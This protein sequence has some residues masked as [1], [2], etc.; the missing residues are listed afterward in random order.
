MWGEG[1]RGNYPLIAVVLC[2]IDKV[3]AVW[4]SLEEHPEASEEEGAQHSSSPAACPGLSD[5]ALVHMKY[6]IRHP[7]VY[8]TP[9]KHDT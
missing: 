2:L 6:K 5:T 3:S 7:C 4:V 8:K 1:T 9:G